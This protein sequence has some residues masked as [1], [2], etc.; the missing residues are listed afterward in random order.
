[1]LEAAPSELGAFSHVSSTQQIARVPEM[2][3]HDIKR[4]D[5]MTRNRSF[6]AMAMK[7]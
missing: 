7:N 5:E 6:S 2:Q 4:E 3:Q 1:M